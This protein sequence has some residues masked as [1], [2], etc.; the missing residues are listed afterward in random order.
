MGLLTWLGIP[1]EATRAEARPAG[2]AASLESDGERVARWRRWWVSEEARRRA[3]RAAAER[4]EAAGRAQRAEQ[5]R[6]RLAALAARY[7]AVFA[8]DTFDD[9]SGDGIR[10]AF[11]ARESSE[12]EAGGWRDEPRPYDV[13]VPPVRWIRW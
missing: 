1:R 12:P 8:G 7:G 2:A 9:V 13:P 11:E 5:G 10:I 3:A 4:A 6:E